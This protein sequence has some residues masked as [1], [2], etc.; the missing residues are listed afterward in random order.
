LGGPSE[1]P[2]AV[3]GV[4]ASVTRPSPSPLAEQLPRLALGTEPDLTGAPLILRAT[5]RVHRDSPQRMAGAFPARC[6]CGCCNAS[7]G[8]T[9]C[10]GGC[11]PQPRPADGDEPD[12]HPRRP[13]GRSPDA[14]G[15]V[16]A[17]APALT[18]AGEAGAST[19]PRAVRQR[20]PP[21]CQG[22]WD[23]VRDS[24]GALS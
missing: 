19:P 2:S 5:E 14:F 9:N 6:A 13:L 18:R 16:A 15:R 3:E 17:R 20:S 12:R 23:D 7:T 10:R 1:T 24:N 4:S 8:S 21:C 11:H 22:A